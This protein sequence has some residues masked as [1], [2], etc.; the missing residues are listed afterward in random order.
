MKYLLGSRTFQ[1]L[2]NFTRT[3]SLNCTVIECQCAHLAWWSEKVGKFQ[4]GLN[5]TSLTFIQFL[6]FMESCSVLFAHAPYLTCS[7]PILQKPLPGPIFL[8][9]ALC[10]T[11]NSLGEVS[12]HHLIL[13]VYFMVTR[14]SSQASV[15]LSI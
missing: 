11:V 6:K 8:P 5:S 14:S 12:S 10:S 1:L 13:L 4:I 9:S 3:L 2:S 15:T 7:S